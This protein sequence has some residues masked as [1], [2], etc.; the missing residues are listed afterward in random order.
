MWQTRLCSYPPDILEDVT[1]VMALLCHPFGGPGS[2]E[3]I[4]PQ[5]ST[6]TPDFGTPLRALWLQPGKAQVR[7]SRLAP[8][9]L[10]CL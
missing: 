9:L 3:D 8:F 5:G 6:R 4:F 10:A 1:G 2:G 7:E